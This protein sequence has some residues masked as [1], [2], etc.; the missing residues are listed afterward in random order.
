M[1]SLSFQHPSAYHPGALQRDLSYE[2]GFSLFFYCRAIQNEDYLELC[3]F[4]LMVG[5]RTQQ[6]AGATLGCS[7]GSSGILTQ[8]LH[9]GLH[10]QAAVPGKQHSRTPVGMGAGDPCSC[11][12]LG[13]PLHPFCQG[14]NQ[15][16]HQ[17]VVECNVMRG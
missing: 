14:Y 9:L 5:I 15:P 3:N 6:R 8:P 16:W 13:V 11:G 12:I 10:P 1:P 17:P 4:L 7:E 2:R